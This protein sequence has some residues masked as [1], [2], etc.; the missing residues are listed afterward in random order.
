MINARVC[1][2][3]PYDQVR[4]HAQASPQPSPHAPASPPPSSSPTHRHPCPNQTTLSGPEV[5]TTAGAAC[6]LSESYLQWGPV[7]SGRGGRAAS[8]VGAAR[9]GGR[10][11][12][13]KEGKQL[14]RRGCVALVCTLCWLDIIQ[15]KNKVK[16]GRVK[17]APSTIGS[18]GGAAILIFCSPAAFTSPAFVYVPNSL[19]SAHLANLLQLTA[20][21][22]P[23]ASVARTT[24]QKP[25]QLAFRFPLHPIV[26]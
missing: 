10:G 9:Q 24:T 13:V 6:R 3:L 16:Y 5:P 14:F 25:I 18:Y 11:S 20:S 21:S 4:S 23:T 17:C 26:R 2:A 15:N 8:W 1:I 19:T 7:D 22:S 12:F